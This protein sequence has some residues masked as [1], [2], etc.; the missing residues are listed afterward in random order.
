MAR[1]NPGDMIGLKGKMVGDII[2]IEYSGNRMEIIRKW[3]G[4]PSGAW[5]NSEWIQGEMIGRTP[6]ACSPVSSG[7]CDG[8]ERS[9]HILW[10][11]T[12]N[13]RGTFWKMK[14]I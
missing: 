3:K 10:D 8:S 12:G 14:K 11:S 7:G 4:V 5:R 1:G 2:R 9:T 13:G 6:G